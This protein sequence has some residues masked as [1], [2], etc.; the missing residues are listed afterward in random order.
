MTR[1]IFALIALIAAGAIFFVYTKPTYDSVQ[2]IRNNVNAYNA[3]L[4][5]ATELQK[6]KADLLTRYNSF[7]AT[8][9]D[10]LQKLL[11]EHVDNVALILDMDSI[12][13][14]FGMGL[15]NV[16]VSTPAS[17]A[18]GSSAIGSVG[19]SGKTF[20]SVTVHFSTAGSYENFLLFLRSLEQS[21]RIVDVVALTISPQGTATGN[22]SSILSYHYDMTLRTYWLK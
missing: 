6:L 9:L 3:A 2:T 16:D 18:A 17:S 15:E 5:K 7:D 20:D 22:D 1:T 4:D 19:A 8:Q 14:R 11:P 13:A 21:L 10:R 12:A